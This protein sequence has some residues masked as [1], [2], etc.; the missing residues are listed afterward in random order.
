MIEIVSWWQLNNGTVILLQ[1]KLLRKLLVLHFSLLNYNARLFNKL[2]VTRC[3]QS[4][5]FYIQKLCLCQQESR[6]AVF[7]TLH[8]L[9]SD[10]V[11]RTFATLTLTCFPLTRWELIKLFRVWSYEEATGSPQC[12]YEL[13]LYRLYLLCW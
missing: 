5:S 1:R 6:S 7:Q 10:N 8:R 9:D 4:L 2:Y 13:L 3:T 11:R 12:H